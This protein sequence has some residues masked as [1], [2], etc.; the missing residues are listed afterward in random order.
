VFAFPEGLRVDDLTTT[1]AQEM[2]HAF[3]LNH[4]DDDTDVMFP[5]IQSTPPTEYGS[6]DIPDSDPQNCGGRSF[7]DSHQLL[8]DTIGPRG[9]DSL[10]PAITITSPARGSAIPPGTS[11]TANATDSGG[12][13][14]SE[15]T[16]D[17]QLVGTSTGGDVQFTIPSSQPSGTA[18]LEVSATD[19]AG[20]TGSSEIEVYITS[21]D[22]K[23]CTRDDQCSGGLECTNGLCVPDN[24]ISGE[25]GDDCSPGSPACTVGQCATLDDEQLCSVPCSESEP[26]PTGFECRG[27]VA[28]WPAEGD[29]GCSAGGRG[30][31][32]TWALM[33]AALVLT[34]GR[35]R[36]QPPL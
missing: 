3:G 17:G 31:T 16:I 25:L 13:A 10:S 23:H 28:C 9:E 27:E 19:T 7:Q 20:N 32:T 12:I 15:L 33:I 14:S 21:G 5:V 34:L 22:E 8:L 2:S 6:G 11:V 4:T 29:G 26:C 36:R 30:V 35:R 1:A 18:V 24:G